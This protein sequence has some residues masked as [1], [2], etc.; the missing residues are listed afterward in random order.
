MSESCEQK[1]LV[2]GRSFWFLWGL[3]MCAIALGVFVG[4]GGGLARALLWT[5]AFAVMGG[6]C[7]A[8]AARCGRLHCFITAPVF[9]MAAVASLL[10]GT[11][12]LGIGWAWIGFGALAGTVVA[13]V[14]EWIRGKYVEP[15]ATG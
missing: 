9:L 10:V 4:G 1:D 2:S 7:V 13:Y 3:P 5:P 14:P 6:A 12:V 15:A 8:N 11:G